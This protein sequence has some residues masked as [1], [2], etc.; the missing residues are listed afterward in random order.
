MVLRSGTLITVKQATPPVRIS[1]AV[2]RPGAYPLPA[3]NAL[4]VF[5]ALELAGGM[6]DPDVPVLINVLRPGTSERGPQRW[7]VRWQAGKPPPSPIPFV[8]PGDHVHVE[9]TAKAKVQQFV[10]LLHPTR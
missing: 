4:Q 6:N 7:S 3:G 5:E 2:K 10:D 1:G 8:Q 9:P